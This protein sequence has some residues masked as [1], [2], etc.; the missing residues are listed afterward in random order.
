MNK[1]N[2]NTEQ[3]TADR[4]ENRC[5]YEWHQLDIAWDLYSWCFIISYW[6]K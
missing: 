4:L 5:Y 2:I 1:L 6:S 3:A